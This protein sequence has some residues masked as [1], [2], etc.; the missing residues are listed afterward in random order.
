[1]TVVGGAARAAPAEVTAITQDALFR[2][3]LE[4]AQMIA[5]HP[6]MQNPKEQVG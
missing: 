3:Y 2:G 1:M 4:V 6:D 5:G